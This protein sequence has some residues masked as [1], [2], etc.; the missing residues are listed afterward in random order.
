LVF[1]EV[2]YTYLHG[3]DLCPSRSICL[4]SSMWIIINNHAMRDAI[5]VTGLLEISPFGRYFFG[6]ST[7][8]PQKDTTYVCKA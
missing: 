2:L 1:L 5:S 6:V 8:S 3:L 7:K 4:W